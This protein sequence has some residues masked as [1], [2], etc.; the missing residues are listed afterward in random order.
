MDTN[1]SI[2]EIAEACG[3]DYVSHFSTAFKRKYHVS[4]LKFR[5]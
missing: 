2:S 3:Y 5:E 1:K 4:P